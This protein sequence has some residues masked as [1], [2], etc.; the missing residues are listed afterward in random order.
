M[1]QSLFERLMKLH[2][3]S[4]ARWNKQY[5]MNTDILSLTN[6]F[7]YGGEMKY[8]DTQVADQTL[9]LPISVDSGQK[10]LEEVK[11]KTVSLLK[12]DDLILKLDPN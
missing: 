10:W 4:A 6:E 1:G 5:R 7:M 11:T 8:G 12:I 3:D 2:P 9:D